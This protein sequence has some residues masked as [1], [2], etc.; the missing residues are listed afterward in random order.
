[1]QLLNWKAFGADYAERRAQMEEASAELE[2]ELQLPP[3]WEG[4]LRERDRISV[5][6]G[7]QLDAERKRLGGDCYALTLYF[8]G[9]LP[10]GLVLSAAWKSKNYEDYLLLLQ[11]V[12]QDFGIDGELETLKHALDVETAW[13]AQQS[14]AQGGDVRTEDALKAAMRLHSRIGAL[15]RAAE[16]LDAAV[17]FTD[18]PYHSVFISYSTADEDFS[19]KLHEALTLA[20]LRTWYAP[21]DMRPGEK[22]HQQ[23]HSAIE[24]YDK[25]LLVLSDASIKSDWVG[26][27]LYKARRRERAKGVRMLFP[28]RL[29]TIDAL[30]NWSAFDADSGQDLARE[31]RE[32][33][34][35][36]FSGWRDDAVFDREVS[37]LIDNLRVEAATHPEPASAQR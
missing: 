5:Q 4:F 36:D 28:V 20:G 14:D 22:I 29:A 8:F 30:R 19:K 24:Q 34:I 1:M 21:H 32:Y 23:I 11:G 13:L 6:I 31:V 15:W 27:E 18:V 3:S 17:K 9:H 2:L 16:K 25:L 37:R 12:L 26:T 35:P 7:G 33:F 10:L